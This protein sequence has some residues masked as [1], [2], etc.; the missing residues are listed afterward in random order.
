[1]NADILDSL[2]FGHSGDHRSFHSVVYMGCSVGNYLADILVGDALVLELK[3]VERFLPRL[4]PNRPSGAQ[5]PPCLL[6]PTFLMI[7]TGRV[8]R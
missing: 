8:S 3:C 7:S 1:M 4:S 2:T 6:A 5:V